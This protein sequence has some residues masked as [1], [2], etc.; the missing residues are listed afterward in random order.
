MLE[1]RALQIA[2]VERGAQLLR[3]GVVLGARLLQIGAG[4]RQLR[5]AIRQTAP[6]L[7]P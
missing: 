2:L 5:D 7:V 1:R 3:G 4:R 6:E